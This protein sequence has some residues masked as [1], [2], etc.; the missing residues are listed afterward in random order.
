MRRIKSLTA[1]QLYLL[2]LGLALAC[3]QLS[4]EDPPGGPLQ[5]PFVHDV[6]INTS[7]S[8]QEIIEKAANVVP[9]PAQMLYHQDEFSGFIHFGPNTFTGVEWG[10]GKEN[11]N[12]FNPGETLDTDQWCR[13]MKAAQIKKVIITVKHHDGFCI[14]Q[15]RYNSTFSVRAIDWRKGQGDVLREL[16]DSCKKYG[17]KLG[18]YLSPADLYQIE[19]EEGLYGNLSKYQTSVIPTNPDTFKTD[20]TQARADKPKDA[21]TFTVLADDY[22]R[23]FMNQLYELLTEYGPIHEVWFD[24]AHPKRK[25]G[26]QYSKDEWFNMIRALA[27]DAAIFGGPD[28]RWCGNEGGYTRDSEWNVLPIETYKTSGEDRPIPAPGLEDALTAGKYTVYGKPYHSNF[29]YYMI[30]EVDT[31]IRAGWFWRNEQEQSVRTP[32]D[33]FDIY[34]RSVGGNAGFLLNIPPNNKGRFGARDEACLIE[35]GK[36]IHATYG[37]NL[38]S[39]AKINV[40]G[41]A[42]ALSDGKLNTF[43][44]PPANHGSF[45]VTL[46]QAQTVNRFVLQEAIANVGQRIKE[47]SLDAWIDGTWKTVAYA[48][49]VGYKRILRFPAVTTD[50]FRVHIHDARLQPTV[51]EIAAHYYNQPPPQVIAKR[52]RNYNVVLET[53]APSNQF[54]WKQHG[55]REAIPNEHTNVD[56]HY[57][58]DGQDPT[59]ES[60][61]YAEPL[62][63]PN[64]GR[65]RACSVVNGVMGPLSDLRLGISRKTLSIHYVSSQHDSHNAEKAIDGDPQTFWLTSQA[66]GHPSHPH[67]LII[68]LGRLNRVEGLTYL[69]RQDKRIADGMIE[70]GTIETSLNGAVWTTMG[71]FYFGNLLNNP[72]KQVFLLDHPIDTRYVRITSKT[73]VQDNPFAGAAEI[74]ILSMIEPN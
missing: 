33:V 54:D 10:N 70:S 53:L 37:T 20:P 24:G 61:V 6:P 14:W 65:I 16:A 34:E 59:I 18:V 8:P 28:I 40:D 7:D 48:T 69:P 13:I 68:D 29:L 39:R 74:E 25:G 30:A 35:V 72:V 56:I 12:V 26:Q 23:Y 47:H 60:P 3:S 11:P 64:G 4:S 32:D 42:N 31:S 22:N 58:L 63:L 71:Q 44:C 67:Q 73:G 19:N 46:P 17:L 21:P 1:I 62:D 43:W 5:P 52:D 15:T 51:A 55:K 27:S 50:R 66:A 45:I 49:T 9:S 57:T 2:A 38:A 41:K 36:R